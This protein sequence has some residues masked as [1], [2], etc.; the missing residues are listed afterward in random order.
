VLMLRGASCEDWKSAFIRRISVASNV[1]QT[2]DNEASGFKIAAGCRLQP[3][4]SGH[5]PAIFKQERQCFFAFQLSIQNKR[6]YIVL[7]M[8][9][10]IVV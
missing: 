4:F 5:L 3:A 1:I 9:P 6:Q 2:I 7:K 10:L 8:I